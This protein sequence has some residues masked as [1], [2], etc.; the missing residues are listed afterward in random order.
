M[1]L[2]VLA[3]ASAVGAVA[4]SPVGDSWAADPDGIHDPLPG[5]RKLQARPRGGQV[6]D[7]GFLTVVED[8]A[9]SGGL[10][11][12]AV[13]PVPWWPAWPQAAET[14]RTPRTTTC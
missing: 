6:A 14:T 5:K 13:R 7:E 1:E 2:A 9:G 4:S 3:L 10:S 12:P 11:G 8:G